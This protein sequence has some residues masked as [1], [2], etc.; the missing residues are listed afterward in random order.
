MYTWKGRPHLSILG[1]K[2]EDRFTQYLCELLQDPTVLNAFLP[3]VCGMSVPVQTNLVARTQVTV[4]GGRPDLA[5]RGETSYLLFEV[6]VGS[7]LHQDQLTPYAR[8]LDQWQTNHPAGVAKLLIL[9][10]ERQIPGILQCAGFE[11]SETGLSHWSPIGIAWEHVAIFCQ[12]LEARVHEKRLSIHLGE[13]AEIIVYRIGEPHRPFTSEEC[14]LL[15]DP[16]VPRAI[17]RARTLVDRTTGILSPRGFAF[18]NSNGY[19]YEG[20]TL[21]YSGLTWWYGVWIEAWAKVG[22]SPIFLQLSGYANQ[23]VPPILEKLPQPITIQLGNLEQV[24][25]LPIRDDVEI[26][27]L[28]AEQAEIVFCYATALQESGGVG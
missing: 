18:S 16:L 14:L 24:V 7:W 22:A 19:L 20:Y 3:E 5:I 28:A 2:E 17:A 6:K 27:V 8:E 26:D 12:A 9:A 1:G 10:P 21:K 15:E 13:F 25:P 4:R 11:L 23:S